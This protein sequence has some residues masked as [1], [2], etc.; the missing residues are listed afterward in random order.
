MNVFQCKG[1]SL[2]FKCLVQLNFLI[3]R[4]FQ[5]PTLCKGTTDNK[6]KLHFE[7]FQLHDS[8]NRPSPQPMTLQFSYLLSLAVHRTKLAQTGSPDLSFGQPEPSGWTQCHT[9]MPGLY[10]HT[11]QIW[12]VCLMLPHT[13]GH[14][15]DTVPFLFIPFKFPSSFAALDIRCG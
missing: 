10:T 6:E 4:W 3:K 15:T 7:F 14:V 2:R 8:R 5:R 9:G 11:A 13:A 12:L 1:P